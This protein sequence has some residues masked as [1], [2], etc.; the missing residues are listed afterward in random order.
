MDTRTIDDGITLD[1]STEF[2]PYSPVCMFC[3]RFR[4]GADG[5]FCDAFPD[6]DGIPKVIWNGDNDHRQPFP[7]DRGLQFLPLPGAA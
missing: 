4:T 2:L 6:G 7:G 5:R 1:K 3:A